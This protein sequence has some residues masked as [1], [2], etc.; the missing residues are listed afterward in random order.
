MKTKG[1]FSPAQRCFLLLALLILT[2]CL[3]RLSPAAVPNE[4]L[5]LG[6]YDNHLAL[7]RGQTPVQVYKDSNIGLLSEY[8]RYLLRQTIPIADEHALQ[9]YLQDYDCR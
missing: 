5:A 2:V 9:E 1:S 8:D 3:P 4:P 7:Y 6:I